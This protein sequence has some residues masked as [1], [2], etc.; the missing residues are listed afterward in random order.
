M[1]RRAV[2]GLLLLLVAPFVLGEGQAVRAFWPTS[3]RTLGGLLGQSHAAQTRQAITALD[4]E[5]FGVITL[6]SSMEKAIDAIIEANAATDDDQFSSYKHVDG[7][8]FHLAQLFI[9]LQVDAVKTSLANNDVT[10]AR[11]ALGTALHTLQDFYSHT[12]W[13][14]LGFGAPHP[15]LGRPGATD[16]FKNV[17][18]PKTEA[19]C[20][21]CK[22][23]PGSAEFCPSC[24]DNIITSKLTSGYYA[25]ED[26][27]KPN[28]G[29]CD[30]GGITDFNTLL[31]YSGINKDSIACNFSP[32]WQLHP[33][34]A[35]VSVEATKKF[36]RDIKGVITDRQL[37]KLL[38]AGSTLAIAIDTTGSMGTVIAGVRAQA[39]AIVDSRLGTD[40]EPTNYVLAPFSDPGVGPLTITDNP[41]TFK[42]AI[43]G[44]G[45]SGGGDCPEKSM[46]GMLQALGA[47][48]PGGSL[49]MFTD[50]DAKDSDL[51]GRV[52]ALAA[53]KDI[54]I[55][56][57]VFGSCS[58]FLVAAPDRANDEAVVAQ[59]S[60]A[61]APAI[62]NIDPTY[63]RVARSTG[64]QLFAIAPAEANSVSS[65]AGDLS[66]AFTVNLL[67][68]EDTL[69][70][71]GK[72][73]FIPVDDLTRLTVSVSGTTGVQVK[74]PDGT[75]VT[76]ATAG[77]SVVT[78]SSGVLYSIAAPPAGLWTVTLDGTGTFS[79]N[80]TGESTL[81]LAS[82]DFVR[83][84]GRP[85]HEG[86]LPIP[87][88]PLASQTT[89]A[90]ARMVGT[91]ATVHFEFRSKANVTLKTFDLP[92]VPDD[93]SEFGGPVSLPATECLVYVTGT[94]QSG[95]TYTRALPRLIK[96]QSVLVVAPPAQAL[97]R[98]RSIIYRFTAENHGQ[99]GSFRFSA[100]DDRLYVTSVSQTEFPLAA[101]ASTTVDVQ[102]TAPADAVLGTADTLTAVVESTTPGGASNAAVVVSIIETP[103]VPTIASVYPAAG[104]TAGSTVATITGDHF[105]AGA[106]V[107]V[108][109]TAAQV[110]NVSGTTIA[111]VV[112]P[113]AV[114]AADVEVT[115]P[116]GDS[117]TK[118]GGYTYVAP[119][120]SSSSADS[121]GDGMLDTYELIFGLDPNDP[122]DAAADPDGDD[123][124]NL[125][126]FD[127]ST[128]P[129]SLHTR[130]LAEGATSSFFST[131]VA[132]LNTE[133]TPGI[134]LLRFLQGDGSVFP[135]YLAVP[136]L[137]RR[138]VEVGGFL[139][140]AEFSTVVEA[141]ASM[142]VDRTMTWDANGYGSHAETGIVA[143]SVIWYLA[144]GATHSGFN[145]FYLIQNPGATPA[146]IE[147]TYLLP[148][149]A[150]PIVKTYTVAPDSRF[151]IWVDTQGPVLENTDVSAIIRST[152][153]VP[154]I[155][156][157]AMYLDAPGQLFGAGHESAG[158]TSPAL[159]WFL[160]EGATGSFFDLFVLVA[161]PNDAPANVT[162]TYLLPDGSTVVKA[163][164]VAARSRH[165]IW[166]DLE[167]PRLADTAVSTTVASTNGIPIIVERAM[168]WAGGDQWYEGHN[169]PGTT[170]TAKKWALAEGE[171]GGAR[172]LQ[173]Y[174]LIANTSNYAGSARVTLYFED[175][176]TAADTFSLNPNSRFNV[177]VGTFFPGAVGR[178]F[179]AI[180]ESIGTT[181]ALIVVER[182]MYSDSG[183][184]F[185]AAGT[186][187]VATPIP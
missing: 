32:H 177:D 86:V 109:D 28:S 152:N 33:A 82:F 31:F 76:G 92:P 154:V 165:N 162:A 108:R 116:G 141:D 21:S 144:E 61:T 56:P 94:D 11:I 29:K 171:V 66:R 75:T 122:T 114:G 79:M 100:S 105:L 12:N 106:T 17:P 140:D 54:K 9:L 104:T 37:R 83:G 129:K 143:P 15:D 181:P 35:A 48:D 185:W 160:A 41:A 53:S 43:N 169:S 2:A 103:M 63:P 62:V 19:T 65:L 173:T 64:G 180:V 149:P 71:G 126:E 127:A 178:R 30:H 120:A 147:V 69:G 7:E 24:E 187:A 26:I 1:T 85:G 98:G 174:I 39:V 118:T 136:G 51:A 128:H 115:N 159:T 73:Y 38:G 157:R 99:A 44:L 87:G 110:S 164:T 139:G 163:Y 183:G 47:S 88:S 167:D 117:T 49:F 166:V 186:N 119:P 13:I 3:Y 90:L 27:K 112:P 133:P 89:T 179:G 138:T 142:I 148:A 111:F 123:A 23:L 46:T 22:L 168:W 70:A 40:D 91:Y 135:G 20:K 124:T 175:G 131:R 145:L 77:A 151:N 6:S 55:Y 158:V 84:S 182:A 4:K 97:A 150:A 18:L 14:E 59:A 95:R 72:T 101:G 96:V 113:G 42:S 161:N 50:A 155:V 8:N 125:Q 153:D 81:N 184:R 170:R 25:F 34:A 93:P 74:R 156:E 132:L 57:M 16:A 176:T 137:T 102:L 36:I 130:Y 45:A 68:V 58:S 121:D 60:I 67:S 52:E 146:H 107:R 172:N 10:A 80:V 5:F 78:L 134:V